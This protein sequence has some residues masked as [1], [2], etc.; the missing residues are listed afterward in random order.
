MIYSCEK[1]QWHLTPAQG[2][3]LFESKYEAVT[4]LCAKRIKLR[5]RASLWASNVTSLLNWCPTFPFAPSLSSSHL[6]W[7]QLLQ[8]SVQPERRVFEG[9]VRAVPGNDRRED[10]S[11]D[12]TSLY[13]TASFWTPQSFQDVKGL[14]GHSETK[15]NSKF[16]PDSNHKR[17]VTGKTVSAEFT[18]CG[19][20]R[21][22]LFFL[23]GQHFLNGLPW[24]FLSV[25]VLG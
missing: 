20:T 18:F 14:Q 19:V 11:A 5:Y 16:S 4:R 24:N 8:V 6:L 3:T 22:T 12:T 21:E 9:R 17:R 10:L 1:S 23:K 15:M 2:F 7:W 13:Q 25:D